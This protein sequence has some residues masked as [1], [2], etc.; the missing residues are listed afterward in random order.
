MKT[1]DTFPIVKR[2]WREI[3]RPHRKRLG[4]AILCMATYGAGDAISIKLLQPVIDRIL[5]AGELSLLYPVAGTVLLVFAIKSAAEYGQARTMGWLG[6]RMVADLRRRLLETI[7]TLRPTALQSIAPAALTSRFTVDASTVSSATSNLL[8]RLGK[9]VLSVVFLVALMFHLDPLLACVIFVLIP[10]VALPVDRLGRRIRSASLDTQSEIATASSRIEETIRGIDTVRIYGLEEAKKRDVHTFLDRVFHHL[11]T[12]GRNRAMSSPIMDFLGGLTMAATILY[13]GW[14]V[15]DGALTPGAFFSFI[16]ALVAAARPIR[17][18]GNVHVT[19]Q[20]GIAGASR[21]LDFLDVPEHDREITGKTTFVPEK[22]KIEFQ[23][24]TFSH[25]A[26]MPTL[27]NVNME[28][29]P[30][31]TVAFVGPSGAG[32]TTL[33]NMMPAF[34][35][36]DNGHVFLDGQD[37]RQTDPHSLRHHIAMVGQSPVLFNG[38]VYENIACARPAAGE[39]KIHEAARLAGAH[40]FIEKLEQGYQTTIGEESQGLSGGQKQR[41]ALARAFLKEAPFLLLDEPTS[42]L[43]SRSESIVRHAL[44]RLTQNRTT[45][46]VA[47]RLST[48]QAADRICVLDKGRIVET[49]THEALLEQNGLYTRLCETRFKKT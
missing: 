20:E 12:V 37:T 19:I 48:I 43:D 5:V 24:L 45:V 23:D 28:I 47:H 41:I 10:L 21:I 31:E 6:H 46:V 18:L 11:Y 38:T 9:D 49:G 1:A 25:S 33:L 44:E 15:I 29:L 7:P 8:T 42:A 16:G 40:H 2:L 30:G 39:E 35:Y 34:L 13:G 14:R 26:D 17:G 36:P 3:L 22:G 32:K 27:E 4:F